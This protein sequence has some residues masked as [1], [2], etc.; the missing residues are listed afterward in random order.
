[1]SGYF[2]LTRQLTVA[3]NFQLIEAATDQ[4]FFA[5]LIK[6]DLLAIFKNLQL[7]NIDLGNDQSEA[8]VKSALWHSTHQ[9]HLATLKG[10]GARPTGSRSLSLVTFSGSLSLA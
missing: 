5:Q 1:M 10:R 2:Q 9:W 3:Q 4:S 8:I 6:S 7:A